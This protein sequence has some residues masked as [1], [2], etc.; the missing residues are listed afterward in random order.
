MAARVLQDA[1]RRRLA[2]LREEEQRWFVMQHILLRLLDFINTLQ[3]IA[4]MSHNAF[5]M[6]KAYERLWA[7]LVKEQVHLCCPEVTPYG[8]NIIHWV[9]WRFMNKHLRQTTD[10]ETPTDDFFMETWQRICNHMQKRPKEYEKYITCGYAGV[11][12]TR[13]V[14]YRILSGQDDETMWVSL[15]RSRF[16]SEERGKD[17]EDSD[18]PC[19]PLTCPFFRDSQWR[20]DKSSEDRSDCKHDNINRK[21]D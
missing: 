13:R 14:S 9:V 2:A 5:F 7:A 6:V 19:T 18:D 20:R 4:Q 17:L 10:L 15:F 1:A 16:G 8:A 11:T 3:P 12:F 21:C